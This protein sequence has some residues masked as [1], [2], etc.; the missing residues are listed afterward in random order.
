MSTIR[1]T[2]RRFRLLVSFASSAL[3]IALLS[4]TLAPSAAA[5]SRVIQ[6][7]LATVKDPA[8]VQSVPSGY[9]LNLVDDATANSNGGVTV[10]GDICVAVDSS[11][12]CSNLEFAIET[13]NAN[14]QKLWGSFIGSAGNVAQATNVIS[15]SA[16]D[17]Y[18]A[19]WEQNSVSQ[20][21]TPTRSLI[22]VKYS[23]SGTREWIR[24]YGFYQNSNVQQFYPAA[25]AVDAQDN[26]YVTGNYSRVGYDNSTDT[27]KFS[28][29]GTLLWS[30]A[31]VDT[32]GQNSASA[33]IVLDKPG[34]VYVAFWGGQNAG[35]TI[36]YDSNGNL[37]WQRQNGGFGASPDSA[38]SIALDSSGNI[39]EE[40]TATDNPYP[41][42]PA[43]W[44]TKFDSEGNI[45]WSNPAPG[46]GCDNYN[47][48]WGATIGVDGL[49]NSYL[50]STNCS[51][52]LA[53]T[54][55]DTGGN[56][57]WQKT[58]T[59]A[60]S[61]IPIATYLNGEDDFY[62]LAEVPSVN[63]NDSTNLDFLTLK[64]DGSG[65]L[66]WTTRFSGLN[67]TSSSTPVAMVASGGDLFVTG[68]T[69]PSTDSP[70]YWATLDYVQDAAD[71]TPTSV[72]FSSQVVDTT[73]APQSVTL[74]N[75]STED[76]DISSIKMSG[77]FSETNNCSS[78]IVGGG[79]CTIQVR[80]TPTSTGAQSGS[81]SIAD[82]WAGSPDVVKLNGTGAQ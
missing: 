75:T 35:A 28:P 77:P 71:A 66:L 45:L 18:A 33:A 32:T 63:T 20:N 8:Q 74:K 36:K 25:I 78:E 38:H 50:S 49:G 58:Y 13:Y 48:G 52:Q 76:L 31:S 82:Q 4:A 68:S 34:N 1:F 70:T 59:G 60:S 41:M 17:I 11:G 6:K 22:L 5:Q 37:L 29:S 12:K 79:S 44:A 30:D 81:L 61:S 80:F 47:Y 57:L 69:G 64:Y 51:D 7:W 10:A 40:G 42:D 3:S 54:K 2:S 14:G 39:Y 43:V 19:G 62:V 27:L 21:G 56:I 53:V 72:T 16:G 73:S 55:F 46:G 65:N 24:Y 15:D 67:S 26:I 9:A 23:A